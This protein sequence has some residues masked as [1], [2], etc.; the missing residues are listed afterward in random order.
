MLLHGQIPPTPVRRC[1]CACILVFDQYLTSKG[2]GQGGTG[3]ARHPPPPTTTTTTSHAASYPPDT[4]GPRPPS[5]GP[6]YDQ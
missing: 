3:Q 6:V 5:T 1:V 4:V 2:R